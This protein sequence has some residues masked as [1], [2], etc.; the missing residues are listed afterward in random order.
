M[1]AKMLLFAD[2]IVLYNSNTIL[3]NTTETLERSLSQ[4]ITQA[5]ELRLYLEPYKCTSVLFT[6]RPFNPLLAKVKLQSTQNY[7][8]FKQSVKYLGVI[9]DSKLT[10][11]H[12]ITYL[13]DRAFSASHILKALSPTKWG[14]DPTILVLFYKA[15]IRSI[16]EYGANLFANAA[17][18]HLVLLERVQN[19]AIRMAIGATKTTPIPALQCEANVPPLTIRRFK[20]TYQYVVRKISK[21]NISILIKYSKIYHT[22]RFKKKMPFISQIAKE[23]L[24]LKTILTTVDRYEHKT[25]PYFE[26]FYQWPTQ[27]HKLKENKNENQQAII[28][29]FTELMHKL[30]QE[31]QRK[32]LYAYTDASKTKEHCSAAFYIP[33]STE[34][35]QKRYRLSPITSVYSAELTAVYLT[36]KHICTRNLTEYSDILIIT[37]SLPAVTDIS[38]SLYKRKVIPI[39][40]LIRNIL[41]YLLHYKN[42]KTTLIWVPAH[43]GIPGNEIAHQISRSTTIHTHTFHYIS[44]SDILAKLQKYNLEHWSTHYKTKLNQHSHYRRI[45]PDIPSK[46]W[47]SKFPNFPRKIIIS[48]NRL[49]FNHNCLPANLARFLPNTSPYCP[50]H[51][52]TLTLGTANHIFFQ[53]PKLAQN[54]TKFEQ[55]LFAS[56]SPR[57]WSMASLLAEMDPLVYTAIAQFIHNLPPSIQI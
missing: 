29:S 35:Y 8:P 24:N 2:D 11:K 26:I 10:W 45:Q 54:I 36:L 21:H 52:H 15:F 56:K 32:T 18:T 20:L 46:T 51:P 25:L 40:I 13:R 4:F 31:H 48:I 47:Y 42:C 7:L 53:C 3:S 39:I 37:D 22:W 14:G 23:L 19:H 30:T 1:P 38:R 33:D 49:R 27:G 41:Q 34:N 9:L 43:T 16:M 28:S 50:L 12:H 6:Y 44:P 5:N 55:L 57:P 17:D